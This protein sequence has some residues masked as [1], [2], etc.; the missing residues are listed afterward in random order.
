ME[1]L[2]TIIPEYNPPLVRNGHSMDKIFATS[3]D[4]PLPRSLDEAMG[5]KMSH[6]AM[7]V[8]ETRPPFRIV[9]VNEAWEGLCGYTKEEA[10]GSTIAQLL[11]G[12][13]TD[14]CAATSLIS[15]LLR[16]EDA[17]TVL[18]NYTKSGRKFQNRVRL[19]PIKDDND[20]VSHYVGILRE[21]KE[22]N[23]RFVDMRALKSQKFVN[24]G[25]V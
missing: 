22:N 11:Q 20:K 6:C 10:E 4:M 14:H 1:S 5:N 3:D 17:A 19:G 2:E 21:I 15:Q 18:T 13:E 16:G 25:P 9:A 23:D 8:T 24:L 12:P 7:I